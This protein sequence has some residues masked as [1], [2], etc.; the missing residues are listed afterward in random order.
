METVCEVQNRLQ[1]AYSCSTCHPSYVS[2]WSPQRASVG[3]CAVT[4]MYLHETFD[5]DICD[6]MVGRSRHFF[7]RTKA[8][9]VVDLTADQFDCAINYDAGR[10]RKASDVM[11]SIKDRYEILKSNMQNL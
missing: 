9:D 2:K 10:I 4:A 5:Y 11:K 1:R 7:N 8:G 6:V 3:Q